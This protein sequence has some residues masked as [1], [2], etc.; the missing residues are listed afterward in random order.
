MLDAILILLL[1][2]AVGARPRWI[3]CQPRAHPRIYFANHTSHLDAPVLWA[4]LPRHLRRVTRPV[5]AK[6]YWGKPGL[7]RWFADAALR[8]LLIHREREAP[9]ADLLAPL[10]QAL[11][12]GESL[13]LF[14]EGT[15]GGEPLPARFRSG[16]YH[17]AVRHPGVELIPVHLENLHRSIPKGAHVPVPLTCAVRFGAPLIHLHGET[18][19]DFLERVRAA[20]VAL[21]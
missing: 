1:R 16:L 20:I 3:G 21:A 5:A 4:S 10:S 8:A 19:A 9:D 15:R 14:P 11:A 18:K 6:D 7:R 17:L 13:I 2:G 12:D